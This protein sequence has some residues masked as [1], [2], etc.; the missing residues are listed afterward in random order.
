MVIQVKA[1]TFKR[2]LNVEPTC[3]GNRPGFKGALKGAFKSD[4]SQ[5]AE[6]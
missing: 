4:L 1:I 5:Y 3:W 2:S 6:I